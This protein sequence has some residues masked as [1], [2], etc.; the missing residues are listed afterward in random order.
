MKVES[1]TFEPLGDVPASVSD[2]WKL[3]VIVRGTEFLPRS[4]PMA[5][6]VG[7]QRAQV[8][9]ASYGDDGEVIGVQGLLERIP[10]LGTEVKVGYA[11]GPL[12]G[13]GFEFSQQPDA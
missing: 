7:D 12:I 10:P 11:E 8:L 13:T 2:R 3:R 4:I 5:V 1:V 6:A 9:M